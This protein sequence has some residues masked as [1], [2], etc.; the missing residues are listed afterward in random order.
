MLAGLEHLDDRYLRAIS[1]APK[2]SRG[3]F[4][5][6]VIVGDVIA[7]DEEALDRHVD[8]ISGIASKK[9]GD[10]FIAKTP[11]ARHQFWADAPR[12]RRFPSTR[13]PLSSMRIS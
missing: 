2:S 13:T 5:K 11:E 6:M 8:V 9:M 4:P 12:P 10:T 1:Y 7:D 3:S